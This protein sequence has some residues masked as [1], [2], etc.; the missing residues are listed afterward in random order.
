M[1][2]MQEQLN[3]VSIAMAILAK[4]KKKNLKRNDR[5]QKHCDRNER[6]YLMD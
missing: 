3:H 2:N 1:D 6:E 4:K 5:D